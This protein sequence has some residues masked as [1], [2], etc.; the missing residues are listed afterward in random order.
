MI[1]MST[2]GPGAEREAEVDYADVLL[3][4]KRAHVTTSQK[5]M[6]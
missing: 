3:A 6:L 5:F 4:K 1:S 2:P